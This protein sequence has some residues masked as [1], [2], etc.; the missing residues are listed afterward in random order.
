MAEKKKKLSEKDASLCE[1]GC[2]GTAN[3]QNFPFQAKIWW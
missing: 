2:C 3:E 1:A